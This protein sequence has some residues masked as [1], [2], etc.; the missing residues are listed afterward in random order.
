MVGRN[1]MC[2]P[3]LNFSFLAEL[4]LW[5]GRGPFISGAILDRRNLPDRDKL[6]SLHYDILNI[7]WTTEITAELLKRKK[8]LGTSLDEKIRRD[9]SQYIFIQ[10]MAEDLPE[11]GNNVTINRN[12]KDSLGL[13][14]LHIHYRLND[15]TRALKLRIENDYANMLRAIRGDRLSPPQNWNAEDHIMGTVIMGDNPADSVVDRNLRT[16]DHENL[17]LVTTGVFPSSSSVNPTLTAMALAIRAG[18]LIAGEV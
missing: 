13:P 5:Q 16:H 6:A 11:P 15:Y 4:E 17:F 10:S 12:W 7:N 3:G 1:L 8:W 2:H 14:G 9:L 18:R